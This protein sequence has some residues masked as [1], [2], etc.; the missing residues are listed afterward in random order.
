MAVRLLER[1][2]SLL[3]RGGRLLVIIGGTGR[4]EGATG[5]VESTRNPDDTWVHVFHID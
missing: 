3:R 1:T 4:Y 5:H 2:E